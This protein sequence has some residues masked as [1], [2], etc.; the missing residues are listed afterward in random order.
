MWIIH[1]GRDAQS[2][3]ELDAMCKIS[4][5]TTMIWSEVII[6]NDVI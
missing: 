2:D 1:A 5:Y 4:F 3:L 6:L